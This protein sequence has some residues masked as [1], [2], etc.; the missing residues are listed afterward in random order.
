M[1]CAY[2]IFFFLG[3]KCLPHKFQSTSEAVKT[4]IQRKA[5]RHKLSNKITAVSQKYLIMMSAFQSELSYI[6]KYIAY[7][8]KTFHE[9]W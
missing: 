7:D 5:P 6:R 2:K 8:R 1:V 9:E 4:K 3:K